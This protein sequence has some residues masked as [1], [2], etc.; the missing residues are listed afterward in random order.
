MRVKEALF[1]CKF[2]GELTHAG[3]NQADA[4]G[5]VFRESMYVEDEKDSRGGLLRLH[6]TYRHDLKVYTSDEGRCQKTAASFL[7]GLLQ[8]EGALAPILAIM[9]IN[10]KQTK[11]MLDD[12]T[13]AQEVLDQ[14]KVKLQ[15][16]MHY[17]GDDLAD[18]FRRRFEESPPELLEEIF[19]QIG[20]PI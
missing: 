16:L 4:F 18:E 19:D 8:I 10:D 13:P 17:D 9:V 5:R 14:I 15:K 2:G 12:S 20:H 11:R 6:S 1:I 3:C 7:K